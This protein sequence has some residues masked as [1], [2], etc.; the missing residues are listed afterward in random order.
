MFPT[1]LYNV[2]EGYV[3]K[4]RL[5]ALY[6]TIKCSVIF[7]LIAAHAYRVIVRTTTA[8]STFSY[9]LKIEH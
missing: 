8:Y 5:E 1:H 2:L 4:N 9:L 6:S 7:S 3:T